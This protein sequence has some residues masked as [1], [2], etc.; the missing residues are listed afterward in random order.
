MMSMKV[1][2]LDKKFTKKGDV[3]TQIEEGDN[4]YIYKR[5]MGECV[6][7]EVFERKI[8]K[9]NDFWR[10]YDTK[11][12]YNGF[13]FFEPYPNNEQFGCWAYCCSSLKRAQEKA[14]EFINKNS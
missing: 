12:K 7:Y 8:S 10:Q 9:L 6:Y 4:Y 13:D 1:K 11:G 14:L 3:F 2:K 5:D